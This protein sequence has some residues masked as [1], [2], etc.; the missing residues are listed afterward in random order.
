MTLRATRIWTFT[1]GSVI[2]RAKVATP[3]K[4]RVE[5]RIF[6]K[7]LGAQQTRIWQGSYFIYIGAR[8][9]RSLIYVKPLFQFS[10]SLER[11]KGI[12]QV[13]EA[14]TSRVTG[15]TSKLEQGQRS[16]RFWLSA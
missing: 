7:V 12:L 11:V 1:Q 3:H 4:W 2:L 14:K 5:W 8:E 6:W 9:L 13:H 10:F 15:N 16:A